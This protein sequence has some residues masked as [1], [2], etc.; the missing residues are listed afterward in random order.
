MNY[1][2]GHKLFSYY[3][4]RYAKRTGNVRRIVTFEVRSSVKS[5][6]GMTMASPQR[7]PDCAVSGVGDI[8][9]PRGKKAFEF[10]CRI[11]FCQTSTRK[12]LKFIG[13]F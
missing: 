3:S 2:Q 13:R 9:V 1:A 7:K 11:Y 8:K 5:V 10:S 4:K 12:E 6:N